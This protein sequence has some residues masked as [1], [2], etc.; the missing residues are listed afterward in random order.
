MIAG[1]RRGTAD[2]LGRNRNLGAIHQGQVSQLHTQTRGP[3]GPAGVA[4]FHHAALHHLTGLGHDEAIHHDRAHQGGGKNIALM[5]AVRGQRLVK[6]HRDK[7]SGVQVK[8]RR[9]RPAPVIGVVIWITVA[10]IRITAGI[11][12]VRIATRISALRI[13]RVIIGI[14]GSRRRC[15]SE[16]GNGE[17]AGSNPGRGASKSS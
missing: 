12:I 5:V 7:S 16:S 11:G 4:D 2:Q 15:L 13:L 14:I 3:L 10:I 17:R 6:A 9:N 8:L 1:T